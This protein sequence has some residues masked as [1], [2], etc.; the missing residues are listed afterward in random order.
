MVTAVPH[1]EELVQRWWDEHARVDTVL[2]KMVLKSV[3]TAP[4]MAEGSTS[5]NIVSTAVR[6]VSVII[7]DRMSR[8][9]PFCQEALTSAICLVIICA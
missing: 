6:A 9:S 1:N 4:S 3:S 8:T 2:T 7:P 5:E